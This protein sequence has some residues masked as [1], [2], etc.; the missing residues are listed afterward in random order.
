MT[1]LLV[2]VSL[3]YVSPHYHDHMSSCIDIMNEMS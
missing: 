1:H 2:G 3:F